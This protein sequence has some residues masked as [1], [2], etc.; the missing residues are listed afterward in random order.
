MVLALVKQTQQTRISDATLC[1]LKQ[2]WLNQRLGQLD[3]TQSL[4]TLLSATDKQDQ[5]HPLTAQW[6]RV[7]AVTT[8]DIQRV[9]Q[10][11]FTPNMVRVD[12]LPPWY[13]RFGKTLLEWLPAG[14]SDDLEDAVL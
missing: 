4:A 5:A 6:E 11:Y 10:Q 3:N 1:Q 9:A 2:T 8:A 13:I 7:N 12:L 14:V